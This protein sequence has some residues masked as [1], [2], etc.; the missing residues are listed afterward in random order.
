MAKIENDTEID[1]FFR[2][3]IVHKT[4]SWDQYYECRKNQSIAELKVYTTK[5]SPGLKF[6][7]YFN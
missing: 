3:L 1:K 2:K 6:E 5:V 4:Y 7:S